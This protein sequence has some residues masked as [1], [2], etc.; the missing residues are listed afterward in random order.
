MN[1]ANS[2]EEND[3]PPGTT[4]LESQVAGHAFNDSK[5]RIGKLTV[6]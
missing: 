1:S 5:T 3:F 2:Q 4:A 6:V